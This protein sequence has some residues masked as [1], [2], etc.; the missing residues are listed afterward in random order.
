MEPS[1]MHSPGGEGLPV[2][3]VCVL[4]VCVC[5]CRCRFPAGTPVSPTI[6]KHMYNINIQSVP[7]TKC[8]NK[9]LVSED[10]ANPENIFH[11]TALRTVYVSKKVF[12]MIRSVKTS[13]Q[14]KC[15]L[16]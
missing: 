11:C 3:S 13:C 5:V 6:I 16:F 15:L 14:A 10:G 7:S 1:W 12:S 8:T 2:R 9:D 4:P